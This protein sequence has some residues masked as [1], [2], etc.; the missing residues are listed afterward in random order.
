[1]TR[2]EYRIKMDKFTTSNKFIHKRIIR[3]GK[4]F[5]DK[6]TN[7][8]YAIEVDSIKEIKELEIKNPVIYLSKSRRVLD[9]LT[10]IFDSDNWDEERIENLS[11]EEFDY[12]YLRQCNL[13]ELDK[14]KSFKK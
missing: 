11:G 9:K 7:T 8:I 6:G 4:Y 5:K 13:L 2:E 10:D 1:M 12:I 14:M 3:E